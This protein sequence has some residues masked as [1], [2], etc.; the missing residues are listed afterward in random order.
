MEEIMTY[1]CLAVKEILPEKRM[2]VFRDSGIQTFRNYPAD[3]CALDPMDLGRKGNVR[4]SK[5][6]SIKKFVKIF[7][8][9]IF[10]A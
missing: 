6:T 3:L 2:R 1:S 8:L 7:V 10:R 9:Q 5:Q 4:G